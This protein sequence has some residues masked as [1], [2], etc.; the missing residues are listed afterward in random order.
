MPNPGSDLINQIVVMGHQKHR[1]VITL[2]SDVESVDRFQ[3]QVVGGFVKHQNVWLLQH[4]LAKEQPR[5]FAPGQNVGALQG[6]F[7]RK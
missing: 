5:C 1:S 7:A 2:Q 6:I 3:I 4:E